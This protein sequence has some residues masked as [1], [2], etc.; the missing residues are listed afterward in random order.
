MAQYKSDNSNIQA[1]QSRFQCEAWW[2]GVPNWEATGR[3]SCSEAVHR[4][5]SRRQSGTLREAPELVLFLR[6]RRRGAWSEATEV[7]MRTVPRLPLLVTLV[8]ACS[9]FNLDTQNFVRKS[10]GDAGSLFG[11]SMAMH[12]Q[13]KPEDK[14]MWALNFSLCYM[15]PQRAPFQVWS[16]RVW[17]R[18]SARRYLQGSEPSVIWAPIPGVWYA[19]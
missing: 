17:R 7:R 4:A 11:F 13:L 19:C 16:K 8:S 6:R 18:E 2:C 14:T 10:S 5:P 1:L 15:T 3:S 12:R 9:A